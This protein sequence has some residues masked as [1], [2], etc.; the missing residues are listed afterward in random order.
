M[1]LRFSLEI[2]SLS[3]IA[4]YASKATVRSKKTPRLLLVSFLSVEN[5][6]NEIFF[7]FLGGG[8]GGGGG[9]VIKVY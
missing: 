9:G 5:M 4:L 6:S 8:G 7:L 3:V 2:S 1:L